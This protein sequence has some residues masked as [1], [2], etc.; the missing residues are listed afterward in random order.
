MTTQDLTYRSAF[1]RLWDE[2]SSAHVSNGKPEHAAD[3][4]T[5]FFMRARRR[6]HIFCRELNAAV[7]DTSDVLAAFENAAKRGIEIKIAVQNKIP[8][9]SKF[10]AL[11]L[12]LIGLPNAAISLTAEYDETVR[13][14]P[15]NFAY[16][17]DRAFR[18]EPKPDTMSGFASANQ[19]STVTVLAESFS[20]IISSFKPSYVSPSPAG[21]ALA[22]A[23]NLAQ[24]SK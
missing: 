14:F 13:G 24:A 10:A 12:S 15:M 5:V 8:Q 1:E 3:I 17:D 21:G 4:L 11:A 6:V 18:F 16:V 23:A 9:G 7:Y 2:N 19:P 22:M 20:R